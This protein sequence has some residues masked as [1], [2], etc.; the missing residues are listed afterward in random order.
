MFVTSL[1]ARGMADGRD[2]GAS[3]EQVDEELVATA[4]SD[5]QAFSL[6]YRRYVSPIYRYCY[7]R[8]GNQE[9]AEDATSEVFLKALAGLHQYRGAGFPAWLFR[10][11]R[12]AIVDS[13]RRHRTTEP[14][15][16]VEPADPAMSPEEVALARD[17][18]AALR[19]A[20]AALPE[21]QR[22]VLELQLAGWSGERIASAMGKS[23][24]AVKMLR[25]RA[26]EGLRDLLI[27]GASGSQRGR[28]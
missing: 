25:H 19:S 15:D 2:G 14:L 11:A 20:L 16:M 4:K 26:I 21:D 3:D 5:P 8:L 12:N 7:I 13:Q 28:R 22:T 6:L 17:E 1:S 23:V 9:L 10:I 18:A 27:R 24:G